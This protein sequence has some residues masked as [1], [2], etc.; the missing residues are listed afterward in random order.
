MSTGWGRAAAGAVLAWAVLAP[1]E[2]FASESIAAQQDVFKTALL[3]ND[4][5]VGSQWHLARINAPKAWDLTQGSGGVVI[6][7]VDS[8]VDPFHPDLAGKLVAGTNTLDRRVNTADQFGHGTKMAG[9][10]GAIGN[11]GKGIAGVAWK[12]PIMPIRAADRKG[13]AT[14]ASIAKGIVW[15][16][17]HGARVVNVSMDGVVRNAAIR[18]AA[19]YA[20]KHGALVVAPSGNCSCMDASEETPFILSVAATDESDRVIPSSTSGAFVDLAAPGE[21]I[22]ATTLFSMYGGESGTSMASAVVAGVAALMYSVN[23]ELTPAAATELLQQTAIHPGGKGRD[24]RYGHGRVDAF[25]AVSAAKVWRKP[26]QDAIVDRREPGSSAT[27]V[28]VNGQ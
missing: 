16:V 23:P 9:V 22:L 24:A 3:P 17:D 14:S 21:N 25:A 2:S 8:G 7:I 28:T 13:R 6:A 26:A 18:E 1:T 19:E 27:K 20:F 12:S 4:P 11:N 5:Q 10:A 15:A